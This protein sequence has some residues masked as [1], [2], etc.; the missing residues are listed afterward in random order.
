MKLIL[1]LVFGFLALT[2]FVSKASPGDGP[3]V[4]WPT[5][6]LCYDIT[7]ESVA[8]EW[9]GVANNSNWFITIQ[10]ADSSQ[11]VY[12]ISLYSQSIFKKSAHGLLTEDDRILVGVISMDE[13]HV[14]TLVIYRDIEGT[15][16][17]IQV[18]TNKY[19]DVKLYPLPPL[20]FRGK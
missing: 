3:V 5:K 7:L 12:S 4:P 2:P 11:L 17:R 10:P 20:E 9:F 16:M 18:G 19:L 13:N 15:K 14:E 8:G 6:S 1:S